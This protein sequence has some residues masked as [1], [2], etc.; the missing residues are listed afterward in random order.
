MIDFQCV[1]YKT[2]QLLKPDSQKHAQDDPEFLINT[3]E[4]SSLLLE[5][6]G[7]WW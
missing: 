1:P 4:V 7:A 5:N 6:Q 2:I 3:L